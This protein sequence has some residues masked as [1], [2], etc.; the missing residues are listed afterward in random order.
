[1]LLS[2]LPDVRPLRAGLPLL[3]CAQVGLASACAGDAADPRRGGAGGGGA[4]TG[5]GSG[6]AGAYRGAGGAPGGTGGLPL[7]AAPAGMQMVDGCAALSQRAE[8]R[9]QP[10]DIVWAIDSSGSMNEEMAAV[11]THMNA[12]SQQLVDSGIDV[13]L[14]LIAE[15]GGSGICMDA[16]LGSGSCPDDSAA[17]TYLHV[18]QEVGSHDAL[19]V[20]VASH[21]AWSGQMRPGATKAF[22]VVTDDD[23]ED[24]AGGIFGAP[25]D[26]FVSNVEALDP[27]YAGFTFHGI[28][29]FSNCPAAASVGQTY[30]DLVSRTGGVSGDLCLQDFQPV[31]DAIATEVIEAS[32]VDCEWDIPPVPAGETF[33]SGEVNVRF[34]PGN[35]MPAEDV[36]Y[37]QG[38]AQCGA[39]GGWFYDDDAAPT[40]VLACPD[41]CERIQ[42]DDQAQIDILFGCQTVVAPQ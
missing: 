1:M 24:F 16:P 5:G 26:T 8:N 37:V 11:R 32:S 33:D 10:A 28:Y 18:P 22:V 40:R 17:P 7:A 38:G 29:S 21:F 31:F 35:G 39:G 14:V 30:A 36:L 20:I 6:G 15:G 3:L 13:H 25:A 27:S 12:F 41:T 42:A 4:W 9:P 2:R 23:A 34:Q 19:D